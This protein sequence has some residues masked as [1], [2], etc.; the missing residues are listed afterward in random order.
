MRFKIRQR[1]PLT[2]F[3]TVLLTTS[4]AIYLYYAWPEKSE[5][6]AYGKTGTEYFRTLSS[7]E[8]LKTLDEFSRLHSFDKVAGFLRSAYPEEPNDKH[9]LAHKLGEI[10]IRVS[11]LNGFGKCDSFLNYGCFHGAALAA[12]RLSGPHN[13]G[14]KLWDGCRKNA[15]FPGDCLHG[16]GHA[17]MIIKGYDL[18]GAYEDCERLVKDRDV[19][20]CL[21]GVAMENVTRS[22]APESLGKYGSSTDPYYPCSFSTQ[23]YE[24]V[25]VRNHL[26]FLRRQLSWDLDKLT[27]FCLSFPA[28][29]ELTREE[30][31]TVVGS[32]TVY[33]FPGSPEGVALQCAKARE[34]FSFCINGGAGA[35]VVRKDYLQAEELCLRLK[36]T[37]AYSSC[38][39]RVHSVRDPGN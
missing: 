38:I 35:L 11:G 19:F 17:L 20:W 31:V 9:E 39:G 18:L 32:L 2:I 6:T 15:R 27:E 22:M 33:D 28:Q 4:V 14:E 29:D 10:A 24:A 5:R 25:C 36:E 1:A 16:L 34:Y 30:C 7:A 37:P 26:G 21:D 23:Q 8:Q 13:L 3:M 12:V